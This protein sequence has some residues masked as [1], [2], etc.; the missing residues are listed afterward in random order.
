MAGEMAKHFSHQKQTSTSPKQ[1]NKK[2][3]PQ[4]TQP[5]KPTPSY[6][7]PN[8]SGEPMDE[9]YL[10]NLTKGMRVGINYGGASA[11]IALDGTSYNP[12]ILD[13]LTNRLNKLFTTTLTTAINHGFLFTLDDPLDDDETEP[14]DPNIKTSPDA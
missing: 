4:Q 1:T 11:H 13:D 3:T 7:Y 2:H 12:D 6:H 9:D 8:E 10:T 14:I 5:T